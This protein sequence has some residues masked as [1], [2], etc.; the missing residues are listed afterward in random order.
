MAHAP[1]ATE[2][3]EQS[4]AQIPGAE[5][6]AWLMRLLHRWRHRA[7]ANTPAGSRRNI[8]HHYDLGN[9]FYARWLDAGMS[10]SSAMF[11]DPGQSLEDAQAAKHDRIMELLDVQPGHSV[12]E[13]G[14]GWGGLAEHL[15]AA[16]CAVTAVTL[17]PAQH[18]F[19]RA[20]LQRAGLADRV[21]LR[22]QD[23]RSVEG[24]YDRIVSIEMLEA[25]GEAWWPTWF[26]L[27]RTRLRPDGTV[28][29]Q[30]I[31]I[32]DARFEFYRRN[33]DFIQRY[34]FPG[35]MLPSPGALRAQIARAGLAPHAMEA[36]G[37]SYALTLRIWQ[38]RFQAA[39]PDIAASGFNDRFRRM[40]EY[41]LSYCE[42][43]FRTH[44]VDVS[45]WRLGHAC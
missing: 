30:S 26:D 6:G 24:A 33:A 19:A 11:C 22:L 45:L 8:R 25:V 18:D 38:E 36:F 43:G 13:I 37:E 10:Y 14:C 41:Y 20:R 7:R 29:F 44:S 16:G 9:D 17:S 2:C 12:L 34:I 1:V 40:W 5:S 3:T 28:V 31:T 39:W 21:D 35:G 15:A 27:L 4:Q 23:Y 32:D 42:A